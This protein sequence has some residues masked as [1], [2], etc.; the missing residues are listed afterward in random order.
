MRIKS[1]KKRNRLH[2]EAERN[3][4]SEMILFDSDYTEGAHPSILKLLS[5]T[6]MEQTCGY[7]EDE[8]CE[9][10][11]RRL[12]ELCAAPDADVHFITGGTQTNLTLITAALR[13]H[14][15]VIS[16]DTGHIAVHES[17]AIEASG[18]K[19]LTLPDDSG[20]ISAQQILRFC[21]DHYRDETR[22]HMVQPGL[23]YL[24]QPTELGT[25]YS[26]RELADIRSVCDRF[27]LFLYID[28][29]RCGY[30]LAA[31]GADF[32]LPL[33]AELCDAFYIG[34][35]KV[36]ALF[37]EA[38]L[39]LHPALKKDFR[40]ILKQRV[41]R[42]AKGR[43]LGLQFLA[44]FSDDTYFR[45][46]RHADQLACRLRDA[47][48]VCGCPFLIR[49]DTNQ[50]FPVLPDSVLEKLR[51]KYGFSYWQRTDETHSAVRFCTSWATREEDV[52]MLIRDI[53]ALLKEA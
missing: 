15:G 8:Y 29:A 53:T 3:S 6:N 35:T 23:V 30:G 39:I 10:A 46:S 48:T 33:L 9:K 12:K 19:V 22:E 51:Q 4:Y 14:Q 44:L 47:L 34:G 17:G 38:L 37:G 21:E 25:L 18:H 40:Y 1:D 11:A 41:G 36:G 7:G 16:A 28:G 31:E 5:E 2:A 49:S 26:A 27:G 24:S 50:Q 45:I 52:D 42:L 20:K 43:I 13:P 32:T